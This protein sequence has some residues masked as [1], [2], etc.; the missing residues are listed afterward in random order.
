[1]ENVRRKIILVDDVNYSLITVRARLKEYYEVY[2]AQSAAILFKILLNVKP[3]LILLD[4]NM[5]EIDGY[6]TLEKLKTDVRFTD[7]PVIFL[8][9]QNNKES[10]IK[11]MSLGAVDYLT[12]PFSVPNLV[13]CIECQLNP[14][15]RSANKPIILAVDDNPSILKSINY[16]LNEKNIVYTLPQPEKIKALLKL[17]TPDLFL[18]DCHMPVLTGFDLVPIIRDIPEHE[19]TPIIFLSSEGT[20]DNISVSILLGACD[21]ITKPIDEVILREKVELQLVNFTMLRRIRSL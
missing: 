20:I 11:A 15:K 12:K 10:I 7:I 5:P 4:I 16:L 2:P 14:D 19:E 9:S 18:L 13:E 1:M 21:F 17:I 8:T 3:D 6:E